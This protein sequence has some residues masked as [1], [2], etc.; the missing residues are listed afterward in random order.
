MADHEAQLAIALDKLESLAQVRDRTDAAPVVR[1]MEN[2]KAAINNRLS[3]SG[4]DK[5]VILDVAGLID[6]AASGIERL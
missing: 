1:A 4:V 5:T 6:Q 2:L 3:Q